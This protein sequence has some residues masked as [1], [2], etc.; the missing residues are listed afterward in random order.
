MPIVPALEKIWADSLGQSLAAF[1]FRSV[2]SRFNDLVYQ[3]PIRIPERYALVI[4]S[5]A[6]PMAHP[7]PTL[8]RAV[9]I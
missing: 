7:H 2:T 5:E 6:G 1:N 3:Y 8:Q 4:R 9:R